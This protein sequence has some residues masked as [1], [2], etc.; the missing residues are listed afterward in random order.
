MKAWLFGSFSREE[1][2]PDSDVD[3]LVLLD[4]SRPIGL[5]FFGMWSDLEDLLGRKVDLVSEGTLLPFAQES[6]NQ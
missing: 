2:T 3:I 4:K 5:K 6:A 1:Q